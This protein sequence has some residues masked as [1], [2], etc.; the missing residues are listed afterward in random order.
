MV[1]TVQEPDVS[2]PDVALAEAQREKEVAG[3]LFKA[4]AYAKA[5]E[6]YEAASELLEQHATLRQQ[7]AQLVVQLLTNSALCCLRAD[8]YETAQCKAAAAVEADPLC[9]KAHYLLGKSLL[10]VACAE[11]DCCSGTRSAD[12]QARL[13][14]QCLA[15]LARAKELAP[16]AAEVAAEE[17][18]AAQALARRK[19]VEDGK[20]S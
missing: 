6:H 17:E 3:K 16:H 2:K 8:D 18:R 9:A 12:E 7:Q 11:G 5:M 1:H 14:A 15:E 10:G 19:G 20:G 4:G 13:E